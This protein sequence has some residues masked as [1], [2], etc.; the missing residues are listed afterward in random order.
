MKYAIVN[1]VCTDKCNRRG[2]GWQEELSVLE[3]RREQARMDSKELGFLK[4]GLIEVG[5]VF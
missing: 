3:I 4:N 2:R 5:S 1:S